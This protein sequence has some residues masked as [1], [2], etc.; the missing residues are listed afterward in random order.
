MAKNGKF[1]GMPPASGSGQQTSEN[2]KRSFYASEQFNKAVVYIAGGSLVFSIGFVEKIVSI[3]KCT[4]TKILM[5]SWIMFASTLILNLFSHITSRTAVD[6]TLRGNKQTG[7]VLNI[8]T[9]TLDGLAVFILL[10][11]LALFVVFV[12]NNLSN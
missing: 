9:L 1:G 5:I 11:G 3:T 12:N 2:Q 6:S 10:T 4:D 7:K 8:A